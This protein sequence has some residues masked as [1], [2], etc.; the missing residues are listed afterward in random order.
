MTEPLHLVFF[1]FAGVIIE[2]VSVIKLT[3]RIFYVYFLGVSC[4]YIDSVRFFAKIR[5]S[6]S[7]FRYILAVIRILLIDKT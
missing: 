4:L 7:L 5:I 2:A 1:I 6:V 3:D